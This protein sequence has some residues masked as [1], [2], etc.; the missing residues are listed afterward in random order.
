MENRALTLRLPAPAS[1]TRFILL[2]FALIL[3]FLFDSTV[4]EVSGDIRW[5]FTHL[6]AILVTLCGLWAW[7]EQRTLKLP[8]HQPRILWWALGLAIWAAVSMIDSLNPDRGIVLIKAMYAQ[9]ILLAAAYMVSTP[10]FVHRLAWMLAI[11][12]PFFTWVGI[13]QF[14]SW[15]DATFATLLLNTPGMAW[16]GHIWPGGLIDPL[17]TLYLQSAVPGSTFAN[18]NLAGSYTAFMIPIVAYTLVAAKT[19]Y[20]RG[21][22]SLAL[23]MGMLFLVYSRSRASW[24]AL[25]LGIA[26]FAG[27][28]AFRP[29]WRAA[30]FAHI[31]PWVL[32]AWLAP[33]LALVVA[34]GG[35]TSP[36]KAAHGIDRSPTEQVQALANASWD[37]VG[38]RLAYNLNS[39]A[40]TKDYWFNGTGLG[41]FFTIYPAYH[42]ALI[43]TPTNSYSVMARPQRTHT[44]LMQA[45]GELGI[46]GG[47]CY[48]ALLLSALAMA[49]RMGRRQAIKRLDPHLV[50]FP[51]FGGMALFVISVNAL[52]D[53]PMQLPTAPAMAALLMGALA[54][55]HRQAYPSSGWQPSWFA[56]K[57]TLRIKRP[58]IGLAIVVWAAVS[59]W[60]MYDNLK[61]RQANQILKQ[62]M[63]RIFS[64][65]NDD[66][67]L[68]LVNLAQQ[69]YARDPRV[70]EHQAVVYANYRGLRAMPI[71]ERIEKLEWMLQRD[72][73]GPN[74][75][76]NLAGQYLQLAELSAI[77]GD[78]PTAQH[79]LGRVE[80]IFTR[81]Q[82]V[83]GFSH[84]TWGVG[85][86]LRM[87]QNRPAEAQP[88]LERAVAI[89]PN[90]A[91]A[92]HA[93]Q[94]LHQRTA[95]PPPAQ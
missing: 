45:F 2:A 46:P 22:A 84:F 26:V 8:L 17:V 51:L 18:K 12:V 15:T 48:A 28:L 47:L 72:P 93:L 35:S 7:A 87:L 19:W 60:A 62:A 13:C 41:T 40:I 55:L 95:T 92:Q 27:I 49:W 63:I 86:M 58:V 69:T 94:V 79:A 70:Y 64:G 52:M 31:R 23:A 14:F 53:F 57:A 80:D 88:M 50:V 36:V 90:Y 9:L 91:P 68:R 38:G 81:L 25:A 20:A 73:W 56:P 61:F 16:L 75:L 6:A 85:G 34:F 76:I 33:A 5:S 83:A 67:T 32:A 24:L 3:P 44:D 82:R 77:Q 78:Q 65:V 43:E 54:A 11:P 66:E 10:K 30:L 74:H 1:V 71:Q 29:T 37:E 21:F 39:L 59:T 42:N 89:D 4:P